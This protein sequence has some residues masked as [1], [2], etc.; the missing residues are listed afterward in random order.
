MGKLDQVCRMAV[1][2]KG[3]PRPDVIFQEMCAFW[4]GA[5]PPLSAEWRS[6]AKHRGSN[7]SGPIGQ[8]QEKDDATK[9]TKQMWARIIM[10]RER[11]PGEPLETLSLESLDGLA[12]PSTM[13]SLST[14]SMMYL[15]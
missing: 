7:Y 12:R 8:G 5:Q 3:R 2:N 13:T 1:E 9:G 14:K 11:V 10:H 4:K 15:S 6:G